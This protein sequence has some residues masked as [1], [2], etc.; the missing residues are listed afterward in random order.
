MRRTKI[1]VVR[2]ALTLAFVFALAAFAQEPPGPRAP[3]VPCTSA[4][5]GP[6]VQ[7]ATSVADIVGVWK[8]YLGN[9]LL[10]APGRMGF[11]RYLPDGRYNIAPT[12][13]DASAPFGMYPRG[14]IS[15]DGEVATILVEGDAVPAECRTATVQIHVLRYGSAPFGLAYRTLKDDCVGRQ[16]DLAMPLLWVGE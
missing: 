12:P 3:L 4:T 13:T 9:P 8:Q 1:A 10:D 2:V 6:C 7:V 5:E 11:I 15:F 16:A 14:T